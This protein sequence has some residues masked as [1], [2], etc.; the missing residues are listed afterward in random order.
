MSE[1]DTDARKPGNAAVSSLQGSL[2][3][4]R[5][6][7]EEYARDLEKVQRELHKAQQEVAELMQALARLEG[8]DCHED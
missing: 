8:G 1:L 7:A 4:A 5:F 3:M 2:Q 6:R